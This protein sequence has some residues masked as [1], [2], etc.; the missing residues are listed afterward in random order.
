MRIL[1]KHQGLRPYRYKGNPLEKRFA[2]EWQKANGGSR[3]LL[4]WI[5]ATSEN[6]T[7][8]E[9]PEEQRVVANTL[10]QWLG[11][12]V[13]QVFLETVLRSREGRVF[14]KHRLGIDKIDG[15]KK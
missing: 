9:P 10:I 8:Y 3:T 12:N 7:P 2:V 1:K 4:A 13:G 15:D 6:G 14:L 11:T 5:C